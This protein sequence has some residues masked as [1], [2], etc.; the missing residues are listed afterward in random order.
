MFTLR[1]HWYGIREGGKT[2]FRI[3]YLNVNGVPDPQAN[4][5]LTPLEYEGA[6]P[7]GIIKLN[8]V[9]IKRILYGIEQIE[10]TEI[11]PKISGTKWGA[12]NTARG[13]S[14][15]NPESLPDVL[16]QLTQ[17]TEQLLKVIFPREVLD[18]DI[19]FNDFSLRKYPPGERE[20]FSISPHRAE[21]KYINVIVI[22][23]LKGYSSFYVCADRE[24]NKS[25]LIDTCVGQLIVMRGA[26]YAGI[27]DRP[28]HYV[29]QT[30]SERIT[31]TL[32]Q[33]KE[34]K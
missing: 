32:R 24:G 27:K 25:K 13:N 34:G 3:A 29:R 20:G 5:D 1:K 2:A 33:T 17:Q 11:P 28:Y 26:N 6:I 22:W 18:G 21:E 16:Q 14:W 15:N 31:F 8:D 23:V 30:K 19:C 7:L 10:I 4:I 12:I 9:V